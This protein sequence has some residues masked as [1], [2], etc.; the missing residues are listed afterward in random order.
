MTALT[1]HF[2]LEEFERSDFARRNGWKNKVPPEFMDNV[3][4]VAEMLERIRALLWREK[5]FECPV[6]ILSGYRSPMLNRA[7]GGADDSQHLGGKA[8]DWVSPKFGPPTEI[9]H[10]L[11]EHL[12]KLE[13]G[14]L[15]NEYPGGDG[16]GWVH[17]GVEIP[18]REINRVITVDRYADGHVGTVPGV[19]DTFS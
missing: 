4:L 16:Q 3:H 19:M 12:D 15:I 17:T 6:V 18:D 11:A 10:V 8:A 1:E 9:C 13:I 14:Q 2:V 5:G 7:V